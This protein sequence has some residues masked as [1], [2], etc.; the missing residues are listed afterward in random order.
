MS[1]AALLFGGAFFWAI[2]LTGNW[3][4]KSTPLSLGNLID[5]QQFPVL[6]LQD[7]QS[8]AGELNK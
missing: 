1:N 2:Q 3:H 7:S 5:W 4:E 8:T 6:S